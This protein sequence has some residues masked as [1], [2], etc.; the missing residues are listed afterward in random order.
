MVALGLLALATAMCNS[1]ARPKE[2]GPAKNRPFQHTAEEHRPQELQ[3]SP[4]EDEETDGEFAK[5]KRP[6]DL[7]DIKSL[8]PELRLD[9]RYAGTN[10][11]VGKVIYS[12]A[13][14]LVRRGVA[15][16]L[17]KVQSSLRELGMQLLLWDCYRPFSVQERFWKLVP[18]ARYVAKPMRKADKLISGS[19]HN[20]GAALDLS[21]L[22]LA[23]EEVPM[24]T[25][26]DDF[27][28]R[29]HPG[30]AGVGAAASKNARLLKESMEESGFSGIA[31]EWWHFDHH[32][33]RSYPLSDKPL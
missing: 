33:W 3:A 1:D 9:M 23:G 26:H 13:R 15:H 6:S 10:N 18:D 11:F 17:V 22:T 27:S 32:T 21:L 2:Q 19:K 30:A 14:C 16:D 8:L 20:R 29:A 7:I 5:A 25:D 31:T 4:A 24:P 12:K 28:A